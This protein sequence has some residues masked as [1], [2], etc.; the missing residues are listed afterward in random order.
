M[1]VEATGVSRS[2]LYSEFGDKDGLFTAALQHYLEIDFKPDSV[3]SAVGADLPCL[4]TRSCHELA[5][6]PQ[7]AIELVLATLEQQWF[8]FVGSSDSAEME[9]RGTLALATRHGLATLAAAGVPAD[10][11]RNAANAL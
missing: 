10:I 5:D 2:S 9:A 8:G 1:L 6:L 7:P 4:L 11:L 3:D